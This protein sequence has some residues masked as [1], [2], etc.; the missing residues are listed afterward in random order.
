[1]EVGVD[2]L[3][4]ALCETGGDL[5]VLVSQ[6][7]VA[8]MHH[9]DLR[10]ES[11]EDVTELGGDE[12]ATDDDQVFGQPLDPHD[13]VGRVERSAA[14]TLQGGDPRPGSGGQ[15]EPWGGDPRAGAVSAG[16]L[17][18]VVPDEAA[19]STQHRHVVLGPAVFGSA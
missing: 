6:H 14:E 19:L 11:R 5:G 7:P 2:P 4:E 3:A 15:H 12:A 13:R 9:R 1:M 18:Q 8:A 16:D 17:E 10:P